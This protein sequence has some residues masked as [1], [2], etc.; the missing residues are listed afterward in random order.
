MEQID[1]FH[2]LQGLSGLT[3]VGPAQ[4]L[5]REL[6]DLL[7]GRGVHRAP[8]EIT[9]GRGGSVGLEGRTRERTT[10]AAGQC[11]ILEKIRLGVT[12]RRRRI[13]R[14][15][16]PGGQRKKQDKKTYSPASHRASLKRSWFASEKERGAAV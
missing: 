8:L 15:D 14:H 5:V 11:P 10:Q 4:E 16:L 13:A 1:A 6:H 3:G 12:H 7:V 2:R 9:G